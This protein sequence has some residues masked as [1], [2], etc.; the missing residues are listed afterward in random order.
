MKTIQQGLWMM[1][2]RG[3][4]II[5][6]LIKMFAFGR[7]LPPETYG[8]YSYILA[9]TMI[10]GVFCLPGINMSV[11]KSISQGKEGVLKK[12][13]WDKFSFSFIGSTILLLISAYYFSQQSYLG[14]AFLITSLMFPLAYSSSLFACLWQGRQKFNKQIGSEI[15]IIVIQLLIFIP[16]IILTNNLLIIIAVFFAGQSLAEG[17]LFWLSLKKAKGPDDPPARAF[18]KNISFIQAITIFSEQIDRIAVWFLLGPVITAIYSFSLNSFQKIIFLNPFFALALP[19]MS[20]KNR[21]AKEI[22]KYI[23]VIFPLVIVAIFLI[24]IITPIVFNTLFPLY[25]SA[26]PI[27]RAMSFILLF[28]PFALLRA[29]LVA[30]TKKRC[31]YEAASWGAIAKVL[32]L[33]LILPM[34]IW[35]AITAVF[36]GLIVENLLL[37]Y[38]FLKPLPEKDNPQGTNNYLQI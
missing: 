6:S 21:S 36:I 33:V 2:G 29:N 20:S 32:G 11:I 30:N 22:T 24:Y 25:T 35:G 9:T 14:W 7:F 19:K 15:A 1:G 10:L 3:V 8:A 37:I 34:G 17:I 26:I 28:L 27:F 31:L 38:S 13:W 12:A 18:G 5:L 4:V 16:T 23:L